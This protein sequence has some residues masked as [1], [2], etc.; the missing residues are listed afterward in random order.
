CHDLACGS[1]NDIPVRAFEGWNIEQ[2]AVRSDGHPVAAAGQ[3][4]LPQAGLGDKIEATEFGKSGEIEF[5][6][7]GVGT[8]A[9]DVF[10]LGLAAGGSRDALDEGVILIDVEDKDAGAAEFQVGADAGFS[11]VEEMAVGGGSIFDLRASGCS[12]GICRR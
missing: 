3:R 5:A 7:A 11:D 4:L 8:D 2:L 6:V 9:F 10:R 12:A 1:I